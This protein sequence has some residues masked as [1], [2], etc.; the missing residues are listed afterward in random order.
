MSTIKKLAGQTAIYGVSSILGRLLNYLLVPLHTYDGIGFDKSQYGII[1]EFYAF[2]AFFIVLLTFGMETTFFRFVNKSEDKEGT[3]NKAASIVV[4]LSSIFLISVIVFS[5]SIANWMGYPDMSNFVIWFGAILAVDATSSMFLA[6]LRQ[7]DK[8]VKFA[9]VQL[10]SIGVNILLNVIFI[11][12]FYDAANPE[13]S[14]G[15][16]FV[17]L[18]NLIA[19][20][21]KP[22]ILYKEVSTFRFIWDKT[23]SKAMV[24]FALPLAVAGFA[25]IINETLDRILIKRLLMG[26]GSP[27]ALKYAQEQVGIYSANY[28]LSILI[29]LFIQA[30]RYAAEPFFFAQEKNENKDKVYSKVMT[31]FIIVVSLMFLVIALN[32]HIFKWFIPNE[33]FHE[34][35]KVVP[36]L[37]LANICLGIYYNQSIWYKL[38]DKT[39]YGAYIAIGG[40]VITIV[41]N[42]LLIPVLGYEGSAW[43]TLATYFSMMVASHYF[44]QKIYPI[45]YNLRKAALFT[46]SA[47]VLYFI[48]SLIPTDN[49]WVGT[50]LR[51]LVVLVYV[52]I[53]FFFERPLKELRRK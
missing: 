36:I 34:G 11:L 25:G 47:L 1:S 27:E 41:L 14:M 23:V 32:L 15:I 35:L 28:K 16:G 4:A 29:T 49:F 53:I 38:A 33:G 8:A 12:G 18:A 19:S 50:I 6:K 17:F 44:G 10:S 24:V 48:G 22:L 3:F 2:V 5:Q 21:V 30:F 31:Y 37:L 39:I 40:A 9:I 51:G 43:T 52:G 13:A 7:E 46:F 20:F 45:K 42:L 26:D